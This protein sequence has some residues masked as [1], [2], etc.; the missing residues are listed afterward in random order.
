MEPLGKGCCQL[1]G[2]K[3]S[4]QAVYLLLS[5]KEVMAELVLVIG[6]FVYFELIDF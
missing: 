5:D 4:E 2:V 6:M 3:A 1:S